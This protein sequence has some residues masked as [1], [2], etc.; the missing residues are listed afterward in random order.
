MRPLSVR[1]LLLLGA[2]AFSASWAADML[3]GR[4][5]WPLLSLPWVVGAA[6]ALQAGVLCVL[7]F[8][9]RRIR[10]GDRS[11]RMDRT[12]AVIALNLAQANAIVGALVAGWHG[13]LSIT[14]FMLLTVRS[15]H[16][17]LWLTIGMAVIGL[18]LCVIGLMVESFCR[19]PP[20]DSDGNVLPPQTPRSYPAQEGG[21][22]RVRDK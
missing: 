3:A 14:Q 17:L 9:V 15:D 18:L 21:M 13:V 11:V 1:L 5:G 22:A 7:G 20:D 4:L 12:W 6:L 16:S 2:F 19:L 8:R 10:D